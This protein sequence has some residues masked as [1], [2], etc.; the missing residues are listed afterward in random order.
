M[1]PAIVTQYFRCQTCTRRFRRSVLA[2]QGW[3]VLRRHEAHISRYRMNQSA[4]VTWDTSTSSAT[5][6]TERSLDQHK[7]CM[8]FEKERLLPSKME[9]TRRDI[10][11]SH[12]FRRHRHI[13]E[14]FPRPLLYI[15]DPRHEGH[16][17]LH[18]NK[19]FCL[20]HR[21]HSSGFFPNGKAG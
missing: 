5:P 19:S 21:K 2:H 6:A 12:D 4:S 8:I 13:H 1:T 14:S 3:D 11:R 20:H 18:D 17:H 16:R 10:P 9:P 15:I 7:S